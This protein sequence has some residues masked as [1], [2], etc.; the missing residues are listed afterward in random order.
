MHART[1]PFTLLV[2][3]LSLASTGVLLGFAQGQTAPAPLGQDVLSCSP[4]PC[5]LPPSQ[6]S[7]YGAA[8]IALADDPA[9]PTNLLL[10]TLDGCGSTAVYLSTAKT[11]TWQLTECMGNILTHHKVYYPAGEP[12]VGYDLRGKAY[13]AG[14]YI[15][16]QGASFGS[17]V[18]Q[19]SSDGVHWGEP[20]LVLSRGYAWMVYAWMAIDTNP[21]S[22]RANSLYVS[23]VAIYEPSQAKTQVFVAHSTDGGLHWT[24]VAVDPGQLYPAVDRYTNLAV[25]KDGT[26]Y[27]TWMHCADFGPHAGCADYT[28]FA[29]F[30]KSSDGGNTWSEPS[31]VAKTAFLSSIPNTN[32]F[33]YN[34]PV[35]AVDNSDGPYAGNLYVT[36]YTWTGTYFQ[37][38]VI[39]SLDGGTTWSD[40]VPVAPPNDTHDQFL[41]FVSVSNTGLV[42]VSWLDRRYDP[43]NVNYQAF[44]AVSRDGGVSFQPNIPL[45]QNF[46]NPNVDGNQ[47]L[48][49]Y[50][51]NVW[52]GSDLIVG[53]PDTY[54]QSMV[55]DVMG[56]IRLH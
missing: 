48:G 20:R 8:E 29:L 32:I 45:T 27:V 47:Y 25:G 54:H 5:V 36:V 24:P 4:A 22:P 42:G 9:N 26:V 41:P 56:G 1:Y 13:F 35:V 49:D 11:S 38:E 19:S 37:V 28:E 23:A 7:K 52:V 16:S 46:S 51:A 18:V 50:N 2:A 39:R 33:P 34:H 3:L 15:D 31:I 14:Q 21:N 40:P 30:S 43:A 6:V 44:A 17:V 55:Q 10:G 12:M 53:W